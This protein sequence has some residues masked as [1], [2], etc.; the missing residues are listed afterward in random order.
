MPSKLPDVMKSLVIQQWLQGT[1][2][3]KIAAENDLSS[4]S[5]TNIISEWKQALGFPLADDL[6]ELAVTL[7]KVGIS[8]A[9]C[10][11]G[12][13]TATIMLKMGVKEDSFE[14][15]IVDI[16]NRCNNLRLKPENISLCIQDLLEFSKTIPFPRYQAILYCIPEITVSI[17]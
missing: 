6:R 16:Y 8:A 17:L 11:L 2:R 9:Q 15:F 12:F 14:S 10:A 13:R 1:S 3:D 4:G 5:V 7:N